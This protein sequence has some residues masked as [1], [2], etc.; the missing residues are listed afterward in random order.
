LQLHDTTTHHAGRER[1]P[2]PSHTHTHC[3]CPSPV[4]DSPPRTGP[5]HPATFN[6]HCAAWQPTRRL[7]TGACGGEDNARPQPARARP[8]DAQIHRRRR[9][10]MPAQSSERRRPAMHVA[11]N[12]PR[13]QQPRRTRCG[14]PARARTCA[15]VKA[16]WRSGPGSTHNECLC[17]AP[18]FRQQPPDDTGAAGAH[19]V[20][21]MRQEQALNAPHA[22]T[23]VGL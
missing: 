19:A 22:R 10:T 21:N 13:R 6:H 23:T 8:N 14:C 4:R 3:V 16:V 1:Y 18:L 20:L 12:T 9:S 7:N 11:A 17:C 5:L 2:Q 15:R